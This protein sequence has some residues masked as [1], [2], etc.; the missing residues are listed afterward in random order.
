M[1]WPR[2]SQRS[3]VY[4]AETPVGGGRLP[5]LDQCAAYVDARRRVAVVGGALPRGRS[6]RRAPAPP[7]AGCAPGLL[8]R[9]PGPADDHAPPPVPHHRC[10]PPRARALGADAMRTTSRC[11][12]VRSPGSCSTPPLEFGGAGRAERLAAGYAEHKVHVGKPAPPRPRRSVVLR[13]GRATP[14]RPRTR[15]SRS[16][17]APA[18]RRPASS[19]P[20]HARDRDPAARRRRHRRRIRERDIWSVTPRLTPFWRHTDRIMRV[21]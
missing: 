19:S 9:G 12:A 10:R 18:T 15:R 1:R 8:P 3:R 16:A 2:D 14:A 21:V 13:L 11:T 17:T 20:A 5:H 4:R 7:R 6:R